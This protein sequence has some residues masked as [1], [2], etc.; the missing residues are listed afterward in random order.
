[1]STNIVIL[2]GNLGQDVTLK[3]FDNNSKVGNFSIA[4]NHFY[5]DREGKEHTKVNWHQIV[6]SGKTAEN[7]AKYLAKGSKVLVTGRL[8]NRSYEKEGIT[9]YVTEVIASK[10]EFLDSKGSPEEE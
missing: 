6:V 2:S 8:N 9:Y 7:C 5:K 3:T 4:T 1:M 10:V